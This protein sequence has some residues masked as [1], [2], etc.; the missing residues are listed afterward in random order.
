MITINLVN[1][2]YHREL[3]SFLELRPFKIYS[4]NVQITF[5]YFV[6]LA[7]TFWI[8][9]RVNHGSQAPPG[10]PQ[11]CSGFLPAGK[12]DLVPESYAMILSPF[13]G[14][15][16]KWDLL[17]LIA[18]AFHWQGQRTSKAWDP[19]VLYPRG[20]V[21]DGPGAAPRVGELFSLPFRALEEI[22]LQA[23]PPGHENHHQPPSIRSEQEGSRSRARASFPGPLPVA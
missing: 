22:T 4:L 21:W 12:P 3:V 23:V 2:H 18:R 15:S 14:G 7:R 13:G 10:R 17:Q 16:H 19:W 20:T 9:E 8:S 6:S 5:T 1:I 11:R